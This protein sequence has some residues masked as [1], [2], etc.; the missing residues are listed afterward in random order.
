[1]GRFGI[2]PFLGIVA[3]DENLISAFGTGVMFGWKD[4]RRGENDGWSIGIG[5]VLDANV[6]ALAEGFEDGEPLPAGET[7]IRF[8]EKS[9]WSA[10]LFFTRTF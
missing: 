5:A 4:P 7:E 3:K 1:M 2:G 9:R 6:N 10:L 8:E